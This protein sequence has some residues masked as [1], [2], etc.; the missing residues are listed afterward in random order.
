MIRKT[1]PEY[2]L[3]WMLRNVMIGEEFT[4]RELIGKHARSGHCPTMNEMTYVLKN[5]EQF[6]KIRVD[7]HIIEA[8]MP[9]DSDDFYCR[10]SLTDTVY[11]RVS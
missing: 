11:K 10:V 8:K 6:E 9:E 7:T 3:D 4:A 5:S 1:K 2:I